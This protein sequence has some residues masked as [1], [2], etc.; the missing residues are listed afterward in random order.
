MKGVSL[1]MS[2]VEW[3][4][5]IEQ[6][7]KILD[8]SIEKCY[9]TIREAPESNCWY[10][11]CSHSFLSTSLLNRSLVYIARGEYVKALESIEESCKITIWLYQK[12][13]AGY[14]ISP[15]LLSASDWIS[16][17]WSF[18]LKNESLSQEF[19]DIYSEYTIKKD[20]CC[21]NTKK[22]VSPVSLGLGLSNVFQKNYEKAL[23]YLESLPLGSNK[24]YKGFSGRYKGLPECI[25]SLAQQ[26]SGQFEKCLKTA[27]RFWMRYS[28]RNEK[29]CPF[30]M[31]FI[32][33]AALCCLAERVFG[34][35]PFY[36]GLDIPND[37][38]TASLSNRNGSF[39][40]DWIFY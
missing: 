7:E 3:L 16:L 31:C 28:K 13:K 32:F 22:K 11:G 34:E 40:Y 29:G 15:D 8:D 33:G 20:T 6:W 14:D 39:D 26:D 5:D 17:L 4:A 19:V 12:H 18:L 36:D 38:L 9:D 37:L 21:Q 23:F 25:Y 24:G 27:H 10:R 2:I 30:S 1:M 35:A